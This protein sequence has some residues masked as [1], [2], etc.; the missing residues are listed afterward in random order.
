ME[1]V[2]LQFPTNYKLQQFLVAIKLSEGNIDYASNILTCTLNESD[3]KKAIGA[4]DA[5]RLEFN[6]PIG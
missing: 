3:I 6:T 5:E 1:K 4:F 2:I